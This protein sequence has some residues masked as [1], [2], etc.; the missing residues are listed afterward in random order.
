MNAINMDF[1]N[2]MQSI[3]IFSTVSFSITEKQLVTS[4]R[5]R[6]GAQTLTRDHLEMSLEEF[7][8][9]SVSPTWVMLRLRSMLSESPT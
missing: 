8:L 5:I 2:S 1:F 9:I 3:I 7:V 4:S 6:T